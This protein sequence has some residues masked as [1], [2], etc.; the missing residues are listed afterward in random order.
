MALFTLINAN[1]VQATVT[2]YGGIVTSLKVPDREGRMDDIVLG[3]N[4]M[5][6]YRKKHPYFGALIGR[7]GNRIAGGQF[8][9][10]GAKYQLAVNNGPNALHGGL[11]GFDKALWDVRSIESIEGQALELHY[12]SKDGEEGYPGT[13]DVTVIYTLT[14]DNGFKIDY[15]ATTDRE[16]I[17]NLTQHSY[18]NLAGE[19]SSTIL[20]HALT[21]HADRFVPVNGALIPTGELRAV[22][23]TPFDFTSSRRIGERIEADDQQLKNAKGYDHTFVINGN[24]GT[25]RQAAEVYEQK[26][27]R[28]MQLFTTTPGVQ[29]YTGNFLDGTLIGK[30]GQPYRQRD[31]F[32][33]ETQHFPDS[34]NQQHF[35]STALRPGETYR[36]TTLYKISTR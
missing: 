3:F 10:N 20:D 26:T 29:L 2:D 23:G 17:I 25:L 9:L 31:G 24:P 5:D 30:R 22:R 27:G 13:L 16:T 19:G 18:F 12:I 32:C 4:Q 7:F 15:R 33:L 34:P 1:G 14:H 8:T 35:P 28:L 36:Q 11:Q 6:D 21:I